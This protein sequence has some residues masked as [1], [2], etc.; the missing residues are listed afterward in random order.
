LPSARA[1]GNAASQD[2]PTEPETMSDLE[3]SGIHQTS[4]PFAPWMAAH[5]L[6]LPGTVPIALSE[7]LVRDEV[8][9]AQMAARGRLIAEAEPAVHRLAPEALPAAEELRALVL[10]LLDGAPGYAREGAGLRRPDGV[11]VPLEGPPLLTLGRLIQEDLVILEKPEGSAEHVL[12]G[13]IVCFPSNWTLEQKFGLPLGRI[14]LPVERYD[15]AV[16]A[17]VQRLFDA[18]RPET[19]LLRANFLPYAHDR[20]HGP[21]REFD[22]HAPG[23]GAARFLRSERQVLVRLPVT[24]AVVFS[25]HTFLIDPATLPPEERARL[26]Q[27]CPG[28]FAGLD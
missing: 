11:T 28:R 6:R 27:A 15:E 2:Y 7:W 20:L 16:A 3:A 8:F 24:R 26:A 13:A 18:V 19:P 25:I 10:A 9:A 5:T 1:A 14:H 17:R 22:R 23:P 21:R 12:T 4:L